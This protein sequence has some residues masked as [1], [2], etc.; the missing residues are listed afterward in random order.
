MPSH[1]RP[2]NQHF[3][4]RFILRQFAPIKQPPDAPIAS[5]GRSGKIR[6]FLVNKLDLH[7][8]KL[9]QRPI[10][11]EYAP[12]GM[13]RDLGLEDNPKHLEEKLAGLEGQASRALKRVWSGFSRQSRDPVFKLKRHE[14]KI[15]A[16][17]S[18]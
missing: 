4:Q 6:G 12:P 5:I 3:L 2:Q 17:F 7:Q 11:I 15:S 14:K 1:H 18:F 10:S 13:Y 16:N 9:N 8:S